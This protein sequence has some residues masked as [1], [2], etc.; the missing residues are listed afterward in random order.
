MNLKIFATV[1]TL[2]NGIDMIDS[3]QAYALR[4]SNSFVRSDTGVVID[5]EPHL[6]CMC[7]TSLLF[8]PLAVCVQTGCSTSP[9]NTPTKQLIR[10]HIIYK[11]VL[12]LIL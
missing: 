1:H 10:L 9:L 12:F 5:S 2:M 3:Y 8:A 4:T 11:F 6:I 7:K